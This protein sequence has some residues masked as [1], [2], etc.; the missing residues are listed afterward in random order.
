MFFQPWR[1]ATI[2]FSMKG[3]FL[4]IEIVNLRVENF[5]PRRIKELVEPS[6]DGQAL[7]APDVENDVHDNIVAVQRMNHP[8]YADIGEGTV[9]DLDP[10]AA[11]EK[12]MATA[13]W[14]HQLFGQALTTLNRSAE[15]H[16]V[17][18]HPLFHQ[19]LRILQRIGIFLHKLLLTGIWS[20]DIICFN[21]GFWR[22][23]DSS[24]FRAAEIPLKGIS[25]IRTPSPNT[26]I[27]QSHC[28]GCRPT[29][30]SYTPLWSRKCPRIGTLFIFQALSFS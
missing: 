18:P 1:N 28:F 24:P 26:I 29:G 5:P 8:I 2:P 15:G 11:S 9:L 25:L 7:S 22:S 13:D 16:P 12:K 6:L 4:D 27:T 14:N 19:R 21:L 3:V 30:T 20:S 10:F 17:P 23:R